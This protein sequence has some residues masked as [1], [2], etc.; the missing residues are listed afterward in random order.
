MS[1]KGASGGIG[2]ETARA[3]GAVGMT[4]IITG[5]DR[6][7]LEVGSEGS[8]SDLHSILLYAGLFDYYSIYYIIS[9]LLSSLLI[10][11]LECT[12]PAN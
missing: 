12:I 11:Y 6:S 3:L 5:R 2:L 7:K 1:I 9:L 8:I 10:Y 4:L